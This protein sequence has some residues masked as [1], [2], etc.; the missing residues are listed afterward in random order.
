VHA[1][2]PL[3]IVEDADWLRAQLA[4]LTATNEAPQTQP[5]SM[6]EAPPDY[7]DTLMKAIVGIEIPI[8]RLEGKWKLSQNQP[9]Q[10]RQGVIAGMQEQFS[11]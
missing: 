9:E 5:W 1:H 10:N 7:I 3:R 6:D 2:G 4:A 11:Q 8:V